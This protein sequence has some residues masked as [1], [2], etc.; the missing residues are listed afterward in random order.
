MYVCVCVKVVLMDFFF[1]KVAAVAKFGG[2]WI[3]GWGGGELFTN[4]ICIARS[5]QDVEV[6]HVTFTCL[7]I[8]VTW[9]G[10]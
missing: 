8:M 1:S 3:G 4:E 6:V 9:S 10:I 2:Y 7:C 5:P